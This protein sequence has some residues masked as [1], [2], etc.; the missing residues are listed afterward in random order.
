MGDL[1]WM[2]PPLAMC[3]VLTGIHGYLGIHVLSRKVIFVDLALAQIA[4]L[5]STVAVLLGYDPEQAGDATAVYLF[6]LGFTFVGA[7]VFALTRMRHEKVPQEAFIG[8]VYATASALALLLL[9][10]SPGE[11]EHI[12]QMLVGNVLLVTWP[13]I[14][15][16]AAIYAAIGAFHFAFRRQFL[17]ISADADAAAARGRNV[18]LWDFLFYASFGLVITSSVAIAGVLLVFTF[19]VV[20]AAIAFMF[21]ERLPMRIALAWGMGTA[22][23]AAGMLVSY[24]GD[25]PTGPSVVVCFAGLLVVAA[26]FYYVRGAERRLA[27][28]GRVAGAV[29]VVG[30]LAVGLRQLGKE[31]EGHGHDSEFDTLAAAV[32]S[33]DENTQIEAIHHL[34]ELED[35]HAIPLLV[36]VLAG[37]PSDR[38]AEHIIQ[39]LPSFG[40]AAASAAGTVEAFAARSDDP[41][42]QLEAAEAVL[43]L[44]KASGFDI[45]ARVLA[46]EP[47]L[48]VEQKAGA[49]LRQMAADDFGV[50]ESEEEEA[51]AAARER[52]AAWLAEKGRSARWREDL[53][54]FD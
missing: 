19:L 50:G 23:S 17:E 34:G 54:R 47:P 6:S 46:D 39:V 16:T 29:A 52:F 33:S 31:A 28:L 1:Q 25:L 30:V 44:R 13:T 43:R 22:C 8:I 12:K 3:L 42:I 15:K 35:P 18:P 5:G 10:R 45:I 7:A 53:Q 24:F 27:A 20:P 11:S 14:A 2:L 9:A 32:A 48:L 51:R 21:S 41:F 40:Q 49:L 38:V 36:T 37:S 26:L 4:A